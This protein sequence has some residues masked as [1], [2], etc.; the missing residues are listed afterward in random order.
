[1]KGAGKVMREGPPGW[2]RV[3]GVGKMGVGEMMILAVEGMAA[4]KLKRWSQMG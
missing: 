4:A 1:M 3:M 2:G